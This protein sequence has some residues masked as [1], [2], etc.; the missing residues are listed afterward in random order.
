MRVCVGVDC[1]GGRR[2]HLRRQSLRNP[3]RPRSCRLL[4]RRAL[5]RPL[6]RCS[7][8]CVLGLCLRLQLRRL[9]RRFS[10]HRR[11]LLSRRLGGRRLRLR[12][13]IPR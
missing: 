2:P 7:R 3:R 6:K 10:F 8:L 5:R 1:G 13:I 9:F 11:L 4:S 12:G